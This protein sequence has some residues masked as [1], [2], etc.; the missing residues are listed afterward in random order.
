M[1]RNP[2]NSKRTRIVA[3]VHYPSCRYIRG[4]KISQF[5]QEETS[6]FFLV[7]ILTYLGVLQ[8]DTSQIVFSSTCPVLR[9][10]P[11]AWLAV[12]L[13]TALF[14]IANPVVF[15][16]N[17]NLPA[18]VGWV[19]AVVFIPSLALGVLSSGSRVFE[20]LY[21]LWWYIGPFQKTVGLNFTAGMPQFY[22]LATA[23]L[24]L[25]AAFWRGRQVRV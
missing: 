10:L 23:G 25:F 19:R 8:Y 7:V 6:A 9:Q 2:P 18:L 16:S 13:A 11:A 24:L 20:I 4:I 17:G 15:L 5:Q 22:L 14:S 3:S 1:N 21:L 12:V